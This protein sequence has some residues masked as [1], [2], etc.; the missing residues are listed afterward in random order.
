MWV[1]SILEERSLCGWKGIVIAYRVV[2]ERRGVRLEVYV[3]N[4]GFRSLM[5]VSVEVMTNK[6]RTAV[7]IVVV[8]IIIC[9]GITNISW[10]E[11][12][13]NICVIIIFLILIYRNSLMSF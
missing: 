11:L 13:V 1:E 7:V 4:I 10:V 5:M 9:A 3:W 6:I 8:A 12:T 2:S